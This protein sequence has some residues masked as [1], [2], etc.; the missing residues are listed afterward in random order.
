MIKPFYFTHFFLAVLLQDK[1]FVFKKTALEDA[2][3]STDIDSLDLVLVTESVHLPDGSAYEFGC[4]LSCHLHIYFV[5]FSC[6]HC[7]DYID[8]LLQQIK[9]VLD[10]VKDWLEFHFCFIF[11]GC[12]GQEK[13]I[14]KK[15]K[16]SCTSIKIVCN[17]LIFNAEKFTTFS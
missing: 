14:N 4:F 3:A 11:L 10:V 1:S 15:W 2:D 6:I 5:E 17:A 12:K 13:D 7:A 16:Y 8:L 9:P